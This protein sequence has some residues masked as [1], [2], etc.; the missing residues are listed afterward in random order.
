MGPHGANQGL[1]CK[2]LCIGGVAHHAETMGVQP[3][4][5]RLRQRLEGLHISGLERAP[6]CVFVVVDWGAR[7]RGRHHERKYRRAGRRGR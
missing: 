5:I 7:F 1:L 6:D 3:V 2:V 4:E